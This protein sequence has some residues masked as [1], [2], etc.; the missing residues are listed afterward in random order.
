MWRFIRITH[1]SLP[2]TI[3]SR[4]KIDFQRLPINLAS[5]PVDQDNP[6]NDIEA[7]YPERCPYRLHGCAQA[8][9]PMLLVSIGVADSLTGRAVT[10]VLTVAVAVHFNRPP[11][12]IDACNVTG[13]N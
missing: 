9:V 12:F 11:Q 3:F 10:I 8:R 7:E 13:Y 2:A 5:L 1:T 6:V 4:L